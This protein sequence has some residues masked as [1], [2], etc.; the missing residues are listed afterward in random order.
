MIVALSLKTMS[1]CKLIYMVLVVVVV[2]KLGV[3]PLSTPAGFKIDFL[4]PVASL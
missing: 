3:E 2:G 1:L 4:F